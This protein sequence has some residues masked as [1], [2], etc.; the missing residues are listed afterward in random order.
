M[1]M[2]G[3]TA[4]TILETSLIKVNGVFLDTHGAGVVESMGD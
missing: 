4:A 3:T 2:S 1:M